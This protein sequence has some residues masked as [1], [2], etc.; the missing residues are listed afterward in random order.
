MRA[1]KRLLGTDRAAL[2]HRYLACPPTDL[3]WVDVLRALIGWREPRAS[4]FL[5]GA[6]KMQTGPTVV[7]RPQESAGAQRRPPKRARERHNGEAKDR[8]GEHS[9]A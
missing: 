9:P 8:G 3:Q 6:R 1:R 4:S 5:W 7:V 2:G